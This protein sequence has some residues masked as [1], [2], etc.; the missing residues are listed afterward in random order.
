[1]AE[2]VLG[3]GCA[4]APQLHTPIEEWDHRAQRDTTDAEPLWYKGERVNYAELLQQRSE[5]DLGEQ[6][7]MA[8]CEDRIDKSHAAI[9]RLSEIYARTKA[10]VTIIFGNDQGEMFLDDFRP[11]INLAATR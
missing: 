5:Q 8:T 2:I 11:G 7:G 9:E 1:M 3:I 10:D 4:H 6:T